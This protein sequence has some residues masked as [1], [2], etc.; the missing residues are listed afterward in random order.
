MSRTADAVRRENIKAFRWALIGLILVP[1]LLSFTLAGRTANN[2]VWLSKP[3]NQWT[4]SEADQVLNNSPWAKTQEVRNSYR[5]DSVID[6]KFTLRLRSAL[7]VRQALVRL[8]Q[9]EAK[10]DQMGEK[11]RAA[12]DAKMEGLLRCPACSDNYV[13]SLSSRSENS[14]GWDLVY[15]SYS[16]MPVDLLQ[17]NVFLR[18]ER[19]GQRKLVHFV[20]PKAAGDEAVFFFS[21]LDEKGE[22]LVVPSNKKLSFHLNPQSADSVK[23]FEFDVSALILNGKVEF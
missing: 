16:H 15:R 7:P 21:R 14:P 6:F 23:N 22:P 10:Y 9:I 11:V 5:V 20:P 3:F 1:L 19:G 12:F 13:L 17:Q 8:K 4:K 2:K 18:N